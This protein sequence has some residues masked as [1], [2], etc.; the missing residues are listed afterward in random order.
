MSLTK[1]QDVFLQD[2]YFLYQ[3]LGG[4]LDAGNFLLN[5]KNGTDDEHSW[6]YSTMMSEALKLGFDSDTIAVYKDILNMGTEG[7]NSS[8]GE[9]YTPLIWAKA[10]HDLIKEYY[11]QMWGGAYIWD[12]ACGTG[13]LL[14]EAGYP[15]D[16]LIMSTLNESDVKLVQDLFP[17]ACVFQLDFLNGV[18]LTFGDSEFSERL[19]RKV[20]DILENDEPLIIY[21]NPPYIT[22]K[23]DTTDMGRDLTNAGF[24]G[25]ATSSIL[26]FYHRLLLLKE[27]YGLTN[28]V[29]CAITSAS[30][31][32]LKSYREY[33]VWM[34]EVFEFRD[35]FCF[36]MDNFHGTS[37]SVDWLVVTTLWGINETG[38]ASEDDIVLKKLVNNG[39]NL[40]CIG[41]KEYTSKGNDLIDW[42]QPRDVIRFCDLPIVTSMYSSTGEYRSVP[43]N[44]LGYYLIDREVARSV[45]RFSVASL[46]FPDGAVITVENLERIIESFAIRELYKPNAFNNSGYWQVPNY[47]VL[48]EEEYNKFFT[49][50][51]VNFL[52]SR[53]L[54]VASYRVGV[55]GMDLTVANSFFPLSLE[56][57]GCLVTDEVIKADMSTVGAENGVLLGVLA[58]WE[59]KMMGSVKE[60]YDFCMGELRGS[61]VGDYREKLGYGDL[62]AWDASLK[63]LMGYWDKDKLRKHTDLRKKTKEGFSSDFLERIKVI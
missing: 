35:G 15:E 46:P 55:R 37:R 27:S 48:S 5:M 54:I 58:R 11:P 36:T 42:L 6:F 12:V 61:L 50:G 33:L 59:S 16:K 9:F 32:G 51:L 34:R 8:E 20:R 22:F 17:K 63:Q 25:V 21:M 10:G 39:G 14:L 40:E 4:D 19:P 23:S 62:V 47:S 18:D 60:F 45:R 52:F 56:E 41:Y 31:L 43:D 53:R 30:F 26:Q 1:E 29:I 2:I 57:V 7:K 28:M 38:I 49:M 24:K 3:S 44:A 13:N